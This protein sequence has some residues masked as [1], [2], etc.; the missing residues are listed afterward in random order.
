[1]RQ[2]SPGILWTFKTK[3]FENQSVLVKKLPKGKRF[4]GTQAEMHRN[5]KVYRLA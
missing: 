2:L 3:C 5:I 1:M 4:Y